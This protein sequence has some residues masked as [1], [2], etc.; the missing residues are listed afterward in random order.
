MSKSKSDMDA[1]VSFWQDEI[2]SG[3]DYRK[4]YSTFNRWADYRQMYRGEW[5]KD[6]VPVNRIFSYGRTLIPSVHFR[7][8][9]VNITATRPEFIATALI[10]EAVDNWLIR[11]TK[12]KRTLK[13]AAL[14]TYLYGT[15]P[16]KLGY[17]SEFGYL[18]ELAV[19]S[20][21][22]SLSQ[23][24]THDGGLIEYNTT[25]RPGLPWAQACQPYDI[26]TPWGYSDPSCLPWV[27]HRILRPLEDVLH[28]QKL[29]NTKD[30]KGGRRPDNNSSRPTALHSKDQLF[31]ELY[32]IRDYKYGTIIVIAEDTLLMY[33]ED[34]L[35][36]EGLPYEFM[37]FNE[38][39]EHLW[40]ISDV[41]ILEPQQLE[42]NEIKTQQSRHRKIALLKFLYQEGAVDK[43]QLD[44]FL[45]GEVGP[46]IAIK[47]ESL[48]NSIIT[49]QPHMPPE[50]WQEAQHVLSDIRE[51]MGFSENQLGGFARQQNKTATETAEVA[52]SSD[53]RMSE[54]KDT[55]AEIMTNI[56][57]K[58]N[59]YIFNFWDTEKVV[60][61]AGPDG[62]NYWVQFTGEQLQGEY[63]FT[64][65]PE[66][67]YPIT[68]NVRRQVADGLMGR[69]GGD[70]LINQ[71]QLRQM[72]LAQYD[73]VF[74]GCKNLVMQPQ[75]DP[76]QMASE[77]RQPA[78]DG[79]SPMA[80]PSGAGG[81]GQVGRGKP[82]GET[83]SFDKFK[84]KLGGK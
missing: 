17:D 8:P 77:A 55:V 75:M 67:G 11:E 60:E 12:L 68:A 14:R 74:P 41:R 44:L 26:I 29:I 28:D 45:S 58:W 78:P 47:S 53:L 76:A 23:I 79:S 9:R 24:D 20:D 39:P 57:R 3:E 38:D 42:L 83:L 6:I 84:E 10:L 30:L 25:I 52:E 48:M 49:L 19:D 64:V 81:A 82:S 36:V 15:G 70:P 66:S 13:T 54:R 2:R 37:I 51:S 71:V 22:A 62:Q 56:I 35:Q 65:D 16:I 80:L 40:G 73:D 72:H 43:D 18:P 63:A 33:Q 27:A 61:I 50:L 34:A 1:K 4:K 31:C 32:E 69:Y 7:S 21:A 59:Q 5:D 46:A